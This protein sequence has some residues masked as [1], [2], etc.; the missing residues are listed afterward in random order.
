[1]TDDS[2]KPDTETRTLDGRV[3]GIS[4][5][6]T[7]TLLV[8]R[9]QVRI[10][11]AQIDAPEPDQPHGMNS[12]A[13]LAALTFQK[14]ARV[15]V[16]DVDRYG[17]SVGEVFIDGIDIN[18]EMVRQGD[19]W[20]YTKYSH[21]TEIVELEDTARAEARGLWALPESEREPPWVWRH[22]LR[23]AQSEPRPLVCGTRSY[24]SEMANC[25][26]ARFYFER[27]GVV[28]LDGDGDGIPCEPLC[29]ATR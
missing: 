19:A 26:E 23:A 22:T 7:L 8:G 29:A 5:G 12:K 11:L 21:S 28:S 17:R 20:A 9:E 3:I 14:Q 13:A 15:E 16:V 18:H 27:C 24:C 6:D 1:M 4:D 2:P 10:R 25:A